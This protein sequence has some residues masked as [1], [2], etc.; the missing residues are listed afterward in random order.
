MDIDKV[1]LLADEAPAPLV[2]A[3]CDLSRLYTSVHDDAEGELLSPGRRHLEIRGPCGVEV[4]R[5]YYQALQSCPRALKLSICP[6]PESPNNLLAH[7]QQRELLVRQG[8]DLELGPS[9]RGRWSELVG[10]S[11]SALLHSPVSWWRVSSGK[12]LLLLWL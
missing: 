5:R 3:H 2:L 11:L 1:P 12:A 10:I 8:D 9:P 6:L 7:I 4:D